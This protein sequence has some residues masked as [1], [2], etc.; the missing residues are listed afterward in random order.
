MLTVVFYS[1][2]LDVLL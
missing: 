2:P 1:Y